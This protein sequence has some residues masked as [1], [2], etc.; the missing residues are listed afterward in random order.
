MIAIKFGDSYVLWCYPQRRCISGA[1]WWNTATFTL[2][3]SRDHLC[4]ILMRP[5]TAFKWVSCPVAPL[6]LKKHLLYCFWSR[7]YFLSI[8]AYINP[9]HSISPSLN[10]PSICHSLLPL[11]YQP[12]VNLH[13]KKRQSLF[14]PLRLLTFGLARGGLRPSWTMV[15]TKTEVKGVSV[16]WMIIYSVYMWQQAIFK[17]KRPTWSFIGALG[18][19]FWFLSFL[20]L[21]SSFIQQRSIW[22]KRT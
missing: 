10:P 17:W 8:P 18:E 20:F 3:R 21:F 5:L 12:I 15:M 4:Y 9:P 2:L 7:H 6:Y 11:S 19:I 1:C 13:Q 22:P 14:S 16:G